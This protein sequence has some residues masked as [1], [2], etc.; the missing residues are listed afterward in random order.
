MQL[1][2]DKHICS[3]V[4]LIAAVNP[5][6]IVALQ[7]TAE[8]LK[9]TILEGMMPADDPNQLRDIIDLGSMRRLPSSGFRI[10]T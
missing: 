8:N 9:N 4:F 6:L 2:V 3:C 10:R 5:I 1:K 7:S